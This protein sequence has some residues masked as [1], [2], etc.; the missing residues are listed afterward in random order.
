MFSSKIANKAMMSYLITFIYIVLQNITHA[1][2][3]EKEIKGIMMRKEETTVFCKC[4]PLIDYVTN[5]PK[6]TITVLEVQLWFSKFRR[7]KVVI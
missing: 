5:S 1:I 7:Y 4:F 6:F 3:Q 2:G